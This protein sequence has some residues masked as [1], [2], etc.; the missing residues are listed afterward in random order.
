ML[1]NERTALPTLTVLFRLCDALGI[2]AS[3]IVARL[4]RQRF[5]KHQNPKT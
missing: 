2:R 5:I 3:Q 4:E 1:E